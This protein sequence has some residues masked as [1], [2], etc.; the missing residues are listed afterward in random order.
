MRLFAAGLAALPDSAHAQGTAEPPRKIIEA[1][2]IHQF[3]SDILAGHPGLA[4]AASR[5]GGGGGAGALR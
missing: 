4:S 1:A 3:V 2:S 5:P